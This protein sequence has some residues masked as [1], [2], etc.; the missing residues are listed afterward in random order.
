MASR[1]S[2]RRRWLQ[3][4]LA[5]T[6]YGLGGAVQ[7]RSGLGL[8]PWDVLHDGLAERADVQ[9]GTMVIVLG[10][11]VLLLWIPLRQRPGWGT[12]CIA[13]IA[14]L[15]MNASLAV[16]PSPDGLFARCVFLG[17]AMVLSAAGAG[18]SIGAGL[19]PGPRDGLTTGLSERFGVSIR[20]ARTTVEA[21]V[22]TLGF[23]LGGTVGIGTVLYALLI[24]PLTQVFLV[25]FDLR[26]PIHARPV[27][28]RGVEGRR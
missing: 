2:S 15:V 18:L 20:L 19:G 17:V 4:V 16:L 21:T 25:H 13:V 7:V 28:D 8:D 6:V 12:L 27:V 24:G 22:L 1:A 10:L 14:G 5:L 23:V 3:L 26:D 11:V 9:I